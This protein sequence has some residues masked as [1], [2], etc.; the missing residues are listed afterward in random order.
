[1]ARS[2]KPELVDA[3]PQRSRF[4]E[5]LDAKLS[6]GAGY[7]KVARALGL[8]STRSLKHE[9]RYDKSRRPG[10]K[11]LE[12]AADYFGVDVW[13]LDGPQPYHELHASGLRV[14]KSTAPYSVDEQFELRILRTNLKRLEPGTRAK[15]IRAWQAVLEC[16]VATKVVI[17]A[18]VQR[19]KGGAGAKR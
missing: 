17:P 7:E 6:K 19:A 15:V 10:R 14:E 11:A 3:W 2:K 8:R 1:M 12:L 13:E 18:D 16:S 4:V 9:W 5:L